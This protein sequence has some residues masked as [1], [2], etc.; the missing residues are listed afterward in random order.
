MTSDAYTP[1]KMV[2][3]LSTD[4]GV[5]IATYTVDRNTATLIEDIAEEYIVK[6]I[7]KV[8]NGNNTFLG[9]VRHAL[10]KYFVMD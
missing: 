8:T 5:E 10:R 6:E 4:K 2:I 7:H 3:A 1:R 9:R